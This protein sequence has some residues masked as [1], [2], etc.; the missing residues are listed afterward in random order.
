MTP[1]EI[2]AL[3]YDVM[4]ALGQLEALQP[5][6]ER[7]TDTHQ[8]GLGF[9]TPDARARLNAQVATDR[10]AHRTQPHRDAVGLDWLNRDHDV[11]TSGHVRA[12]GNVAGLSVDADIAFTLHD[13]VDKTTWWLNRRAGI[14]Y[15]GRDELPAEPT[16]PQLI[17]RLRGLVVLTEDQRRLHHV[18][19]EVQRL[20][21]DATYLVD[22]DD[23]SRLDDP[24]PHC[25]RDTLVVRWREDL[26]RCG[27]DQ[28]T[29]AFAFC[30]CAD[31]LCECKARPIAY[32]HEWH[33]TDQAAGDRRHTWKALNNLLTT[34]RAANQQG[35]PA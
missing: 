24:C 29:G 11:K 6:V 22:G 13:L 33:R 27:R 5:L 16:A 21:E 17:V 34:R 14:C 30:R 19:R 32:R 28:H 1:E 10:L 31:P 9:L 25:G 4:V 12:P 20:N 8:R 35:A 2:A 26:I 15:A 7:L 23:Q 3:Q 18:W